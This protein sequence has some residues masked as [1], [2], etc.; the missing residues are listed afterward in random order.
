MNWTDDYGC[1]YNFEESNLKFPKSSSFD[2]VISQKKF[3]WD[4][5]KIEIDEGNCESSRCGFKLYANR[6]LTVHCKDKRNYCKVVDEM[7]VMEALPKL[8]DRLD[9][10]TKA[11]NG[12]IDELVFRVPFIKKVREDDIVSGCTYVQINRDK[13]TFEIKNGDRCPI[14]VK[15]F[16]N[17]YHLFELSKSKEGKPE[18]HKAMLFSKDE[19][20]LFDKQVPLVQD[21]FAIGLCSESKCEVYNYKK[22][23]P[24]KFKIECEIIKR[25]KENP[26]IIELISE[27][28]CPIKVDNEKRIFLRSIKADNGCY[29]A[30]ITK[31]IDSSTFE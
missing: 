30:F 29:K 19:S 24:Q 6:L 15:I 16:E 9:F 21:F 27:G 10:C 17:K 13:S 18:I 11:S 22:R 25:N 28:I 23:Q 1:F 26:N 12:E 3:K 20:R 31:K 4:D 14:W 5:L 7:Y 2:S 8:Q